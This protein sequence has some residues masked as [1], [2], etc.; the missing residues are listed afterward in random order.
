MSRYR[1][2]MEWWTDFWTWVNENQLAATVVGGLILA[3]FATLP[4]IRPHVRS[5]LKWPLTVRFTTAQKIRQV[6]A[7]ISSK[8]QTISDLKSQVESARAEGVRL[9]EERRSQAE[10]KFAEERLKHER[11]LEASRL[12]GI[13]EGRK[14]AFAEIEVERTRPSKKPVWRVDPVQSDVTYQLANTQADAIAKDV[15]IEAHHQ[16]FAFTGGTQWSG[17]LGSTQTFDGHRLKIGRQL[18]VKFVI[19]YRDER[20]DWHEAYA[21]IDREPLRSVIF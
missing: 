2:G 3:L 6:V 11:A 16:E 10:T 19:R 14:E 8:D 20:G 12:E 17:I 21:T 4:K 18:G 7:E 1:R 5:A 9:G 13:E 15:S